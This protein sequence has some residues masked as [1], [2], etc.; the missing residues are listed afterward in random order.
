M[1]N[2]ELL[3]EAVCISGSNDLLRGSLWMV[4]FALLRNR[5]VVF[6]IHDLYV[7]CFSAIIRKHVA[8]CTWACIN[9]SEVNWTLRGKTVTN[10]L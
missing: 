3:Q 4:F 9:F 8:P 6:K 7:I 1:G 10:I 2:E 5:C